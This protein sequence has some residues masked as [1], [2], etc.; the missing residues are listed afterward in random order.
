MTSVNE[1]NAQQRAYKEGKRDGYDIGYSTAM[2]TAWKH[3]TELRWS[4]LALAFVIG[5]M[6]AIA[7]EA[8]AQ[9][10][11]PTTVTV[12]IS[13]EVPCNPTNCPEIPV[14][15]PAVIQNVTQEQTLLQRI[16]SAIVR[17]LT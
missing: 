11:I 9:T 3:G 10:S 13:A 1:L 17:A 5:F 14:E 12:T 7:T 8:S 4:K 6:V 2:E 16:W 15:K